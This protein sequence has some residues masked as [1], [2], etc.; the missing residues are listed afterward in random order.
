MLIALALRGN[1]RRGAP[2]ELWLVAH[3]PTGLPTAARS[4]LR[5]TNAFHF[6]LGQPTEHDLISDALGVVG[7]TVD[8]LCPPPP[9]PSPRPQTTS[10]SASLPPDPTLTANETQ[11]AGSI[12]QFSN[13][14]DREGNSSAMP[15]D[16]CT[17]HFS[18]RAAKSCDEISSRP[19]MYTRGLAFVRYRVT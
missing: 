18:L 14:A 7:L 11:F 12:N 8:R 19:H 16:S 2:R 1:A 5:H 3:V 13:K 10:S 4:Q 15:M 9:V 6:R 17:K